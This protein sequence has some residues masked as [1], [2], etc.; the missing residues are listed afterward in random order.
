[1]KTFTYVEEYLEVINGDRDPNTGRLY[2]LFNTT[3]P[4]VSLARY[5]V[6]ILASMSDATQNGRAL[7][8]KQADLAVKL[9]LKYRKQ[10]E[11]NLIDVSPVEQPKFKLGIRLIDRRRILTIENNTIILKFPYET[12]LIN[13]IRDLAKESQGK[14]IFNNENKTWNVAITELNVV[15]VHGFAKNNNFE[16]ADE[17][18]KY[19]Q[20]VID[21]E[22]VPYEIK[23]TCNRDKL[24]I[25]NAPKSLID[26]IDNLGGFDFDNLDCLVDNSSL[27]AYEIDKEIEQLLCNKYSPRVFNLMQTK[28]SKFSPNEDNEVY[29]DLVEYANI[30]NRYPIYVYEPDLSGRLYKNFVLKFFSNEEIYISKNLNKEK[31]DL[32][33]KIVYFNKYSSTWD[34]PIPLLISGQGMMYGGEKSLLLQDAKKV[35]YFATEV[36]NATSTKGKIK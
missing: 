8:D 9:I 22:T 21:C 2:G 29:K 10:L 12:Q 25:T 11:K 20:L 18:Q 33:K 34:H 5:D 15:A 26:A 28:E 30:T 24:E 4:I 27:Y 1:M 36:Y 16:V 14:W 35:V 23:L 13:D 31:A 17:F 32:D 19:Y 6:N 7:T 3:P